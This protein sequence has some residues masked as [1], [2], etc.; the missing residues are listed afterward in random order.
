MS[1]DRN[2]DIPQT[3]PAGV[4][5]MTQPHTSTIPLYKIAPSSHITFAWSLS[6][7]IPTVAPT[8]ITIKAI[9][10]NGY[11]YNIGPDEGTIDGKATSV[12]WN[13][14]EHNQANPTLA[15]KQGEYR[16]RMWDDRGPG[17]VRTGSIG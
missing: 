15:F 5:V 7:V 9:G 6:D 13:P 11:T 14:Y 10:D 1:D 4:L 17:L 3:A 16:V 12:V 8:S 2:P